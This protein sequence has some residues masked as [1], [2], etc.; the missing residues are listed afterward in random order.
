MQFYHSALSL[1]LVSLTEEKLPVS[2]K[3][4]VVESS[5][6]YKTKKW[7]CAVALIDSFG[8]K[9]V[10][11]YLWLNKDDKW[12]RQE[13]FIIHNKKEWDQIRGS[14]ENFIDKLS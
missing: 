10:A 9:Q 4:T 13:K 2:E 7:W 11:V 14:V 3:L 8:R 12:K 1:S 5:T 6:L